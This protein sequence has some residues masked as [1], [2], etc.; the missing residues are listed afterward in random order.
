MLSPV[1]P[2]LSELNSKGTCKPDAFGFLNCT[3]LYEYSFSH[4]SCVFAQNMQ[5]LQAQEAEECS[6]CDIEI[7]NIG[8]PPDNTAALSDPETPDSLHSR[9]SP[10]S[11]LSLSRVLLKVDYCPQVVAELRE[12]RGLQQMSLVIN[13][14]YFCNTEEDLCGGAKGEFEE[15]SES[16]EVT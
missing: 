1:N 9:G 4:H 7:V 15:R 3:L 2:R 11:T 12:G 10:P 8:P 5:R 14:A 16:G 6:G 13:D